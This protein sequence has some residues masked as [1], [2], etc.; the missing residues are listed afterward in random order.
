MMTAVKTSLIESACS[1]WAQAEKFSNLPF[2][3]MNPGGA[4]FCSTKL[5][6]FLPL[7]TESP[8]I[9]QSSVKIKPDKVHHEFLLRVCEER[10]TYFKLVMTIEKEV[11]VE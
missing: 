8:P 1:V 3:L 5:P 4:Q 11:L 6:C 9:S 10:C 7:R 2:C